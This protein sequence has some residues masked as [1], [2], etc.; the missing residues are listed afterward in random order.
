MTMYKPSSVFTNLSLIHFLDDQIQCVCSIATWLRRFCDPLTFNEHFDFCKLGTH[1]RT[2][3]L[4]IIQHSGLH[5]ALKQGLNHVV[6]RPTN[7]A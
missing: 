3:D 4:N 1:V 5:Q 2:M 6:L 7:I